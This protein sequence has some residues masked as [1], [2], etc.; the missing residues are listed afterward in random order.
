MEKGGSMVAS[1]LLHRCSSR[2][3][4]SG[5]CDATVLQSQQCNALAAWGRPRR[6]PN[7]DR[8]SASCT[9]LLLLTDAYK[10]PLLAF[11]CGCSRSADDS[12]Q[13]KDAGWPDWKVELRLLFLSDPDAQR[14][15][16]KLPVFHAGYAQRYICSATTLTSACELPT[17]T[18]EKQ[19]FR[20]DLAG[21]PRTCPDPARAVRSCLHPAETALPEGSARLLAYSA[22][23][24]RIE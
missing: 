2:T 21:Q 10:Y 18:R 11:D 24:C 19:A 23:E 14:N 5:A 6:R 15:H 12:V 9:L 8:W 17:T 13:R 22:F 20:P 4:V 1:S 16:H 7:G 3:S